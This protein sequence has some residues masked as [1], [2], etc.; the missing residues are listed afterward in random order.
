MSFRAPY[1]ERQ[2]GDACR[3]H[4]LNALFGRA[5]ID[6][7]RLKE[8]AHEFDAHYGYHVTDQFDCVQSDSLTLV[9]FI[10]EQ[11]CKYVTHYVPLHRSSPLPVQLK[12]LMDP[13]V[14]ALLLFNANHIWCVRKWDE[15]DG[16]WYN[17][18]SL[19]GRPLRLMEVP[20]LPA[21]T[22]AILIHTQAHALQVLL[23]QYQRDVCAYVRAHKLNTEQ[24]VRQWLQAVKELGT[25]ETAMCNFL[26]VY[27]SQ[28]GANADVKVKYDQLLKALGPT[29]RENLWTVVLPLIQ[30]IVRFECTP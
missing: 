6:E 28:Q 27:C 15:G 3:V 26:R 11:R 24:A 13:R 18:D 2:R 29:L 8:W 7:A 1:S 25:L 16:A 19:M 23:P 5:V 20:A 30:F 9:S 10:L 22:G 4:A 12:P 14:P 17:L 21:Q